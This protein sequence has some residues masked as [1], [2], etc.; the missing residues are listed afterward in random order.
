M[1]NRINK[2]CPIVLRKVNSQ[3]QILAFR[4]PLAGNQIVKGTVE[5]GESLIQA[6]ARELKEESGITAIA[7]TYLGTWDAEYKNQI[8]GMH[9]MQV[10]G[11]LP[12]SW[13]HTALDDGG[14]DFQFF[15]QDLNQTLDDQ[16]H[17]VFVRA[18]D[19]IKQSIVSHNPEIQ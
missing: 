6:A 12:E 2:T 7:N 19:F 1:Q 15:W 17:P 5:A 18:I 10:K 14:H 3:I 13:T 4:H 11:K 16:W 8:W 9:L